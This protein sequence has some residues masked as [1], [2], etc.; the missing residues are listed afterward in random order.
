MLAT[1]AIVLSATGNN[2]FACKADTINLCSIGG[3]NYDQVPDCSVKWMYND[4]TSCSGELNC[5]SE[6]SQA[7]QL[8]QGG[9]GC[10]L[11]MMSQTPVTPPAP[12]APPASEKLSSGAIG[13]IVVGAYLGVAGAF[14][15]FGVYRGYAAG[16]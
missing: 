13:G 4:L 7:F 14:G 3:L 11:C 5:V 1:L 15:A 6:C 10:Y 16:V 9:P 12:P 8:A 2:R